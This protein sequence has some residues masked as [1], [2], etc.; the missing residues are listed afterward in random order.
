MFLILPTMIWLLKNLPQRK[1]ENEKDQLRRTKENILQRGQLKT[2][3]ESAGAF[4]KAFNGGYKNLKF[5]KDAQFQARLKQVIPFPNGSPIPKSIINKLKGGRAVGHCTASCNLNNKPGNPKE[6]YDGDLHGDLD[7]GIFA[8]GLK[9]FCTVRGH[10]P[11]SH[12]NGIWLVPLA[13]LLMGIQH[14]CRTHKKDLN[15][16]FGWVAII[17]LFVDDMEF[18][19]IRKFLEFCQLAKM[20]H[21]TRIRFCWWQQRRWA[22]ETLGDKGG[23]KEKLLKY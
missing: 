18:D 4:T 17:V 23:L 16:S 14:V 8:R 22:R 3:W 5:G 11:N 13:W 21:A 9:P 10:I 12:I 20:M 1:K 2:D 19:K 6:Y 15:R 7:S